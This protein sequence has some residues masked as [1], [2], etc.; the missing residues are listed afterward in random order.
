MKGGGDGNI[1]LD[2]INWSIF[3][4][5]IWERESFVGNYSVGFYN[6]ASG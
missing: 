5:W 2:R 3:F 4:V 6:D 1:I